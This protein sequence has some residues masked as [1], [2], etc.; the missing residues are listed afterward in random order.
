MQVGD[1]FDHILLAN[2]SFMSVKTERSSQN[3]SISTPLNP[4][5]LFD[6]T[7]GSNRLYLYKHE[8][9]NRYIIKIS[10]EAKNVDTLHLRKFSQ[11]MSESQWF[12]SGEENAT[13]EG[14]FFSI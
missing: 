7:L 12:K 11:P 2:K 6:S 5:L 3:Q 1:Q 4:T 9:I 13:I 8:Y 14:Y 10:S